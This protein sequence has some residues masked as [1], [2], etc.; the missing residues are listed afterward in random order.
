[1]ELPTKPP[2]FSDFVVVKEL[3]PFIEDIKVRYKEL[4]KEQLF[5]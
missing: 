3:I 2:I 5:Y 4:Q 1:M